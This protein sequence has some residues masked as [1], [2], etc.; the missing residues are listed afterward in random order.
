MLA[1]SLQKFLEALSLSVLKMHNIH[2]ILIE[3][4]QAIRNQ[5]SHSFLPVVRVMNDYYMTIPES[6]RPRICAIAISSGSTPSSFDSKMLRLEQ[7]LN[8]L[9]SGVTAERRQKVSDLP[10]RPEEKVILYDQVSAQQTKTALYKQLRDI[11]KNKRIARKYFRAADT[12]SAQLGSC[13]ADLVWKP[14]LKDIEESIPTWHEDDGSDPSQRVLLQIR[15]TIR[16]CTF[17]MPNLNPSAAGF[18]VSHKFLR[19]LQALESCKGYGETLKGVVL[20]KSSSTPE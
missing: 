2:S 13:A 19:L 11:D 5:D 7:V 16:N 9:V 14:A 18:N 15:D 4:V 1:H 17:S 8:S 3:D 12:A 20:G 6:S 10:D